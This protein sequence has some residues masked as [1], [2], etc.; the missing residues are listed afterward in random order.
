MQNSNI[1]AVAKGKPCPN[2]ANVP[3]A[4]HNNLSDKELYR[5]CQLYGGEARKWM[6][7]FAALLP[8]VAR[9]ELYKKHGF[10]SIFEFAAKLAG[11]KHET[12]VE[13][14]RIAK[15]L[16]DKPLLLNQLAEQ[17]INKLRLVANIATK[18]N[19]AALCEKIKEMS[20][21]TLATFIQEKFRAGTGSGLNDTTIGSGQ[22]RIT[23]SIPFEPKVELQLRELQKKLSRECGFPIELNEVIKTLLETFQNAENKKSTGSAK[24]TAKIAG[25]NKPVASTITVLNFQRMQSQIPDV[26]LNNKPHKLTPAQTPTALPTSA[27]S[28]R[29]KPPSRHIP[30]KIKE[31]LYQKFAG[32]CAWPG[33]LKLPEIYHH[34]LRFSLN[35]SHNPDYLAPLCKNHERL[36]HHGLI[37]NEEESPQT[38]RL[39]FEPDKSES[40]YQIDQ[41]VINRR[42][43]ENFP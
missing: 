32:R 6:R 33:C 20:K 28:Q 19:E 4:C 36:A 11:M 37:E 13:I 7:K 17:G 23:I 34:T 41:K 29:P 21:A 27:Q 1:R 31:I 2:E 16:K 35:P 18:E 30:S 40:K 39:K 14:L 5:K 25:P 10:Y 15:K 12:V 24:T 8:E 9:R 43:A 3:G 26:R 22:K 42:L 38:W